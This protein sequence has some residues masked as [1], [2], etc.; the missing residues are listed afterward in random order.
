M[1]SPWDFASASKRADA[2]VTVAER[3]AVRDAVHIVLRDRQGSGRLFT[4]MRANA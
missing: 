2:T 4:D 1:K 3:V